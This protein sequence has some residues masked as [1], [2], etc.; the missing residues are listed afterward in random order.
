[1]IDMRDVFRSRIMTALDLGVAAATAW[2]I[3]FVVFMLNGVG[4]MLR[5]V[6]KEDIGWYGQ[7]IAMSEANQ[8]FA[9]AGYI[10]V[11]HFSL[12][13]IYWAVRKGRSRFPAASD[14]SAFVL[15]SL[16]GV[17]YLPSFL[18]TMAITG[19]HFETLSPN[20]LC[21]IANNYSFG[22]TEEGRETGAGFA[23]AVLLFKAAVIGFPAFAYGYGMFR[24][25]K[26][27]TLKSF[28]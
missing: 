7:T 10:V 15:A 2:A 28:A 3:M 24:P 8:I 27:Y 17:A 23:T 14:A 21:M 4:A 6:V 1:M 16:V 25:I 20:W 11:S 19:V 26:P 12:L 13:A 22:M 18:G 9:L 5:P